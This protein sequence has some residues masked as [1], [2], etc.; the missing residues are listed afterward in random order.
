M[1]HV[2]IFIMLKGMGRLVALKVPERFM[3]ARHN[4]RIKRS[5]RCRPKI[6]NNTSIK[7]IASSEGKRDGNDPHN[8]LQDRNRKYNHSII[9]IDCHLHLEVP[10][11]IITLGNMPFLYYYFI[12]RQRFL[13]ICFVGRKKHC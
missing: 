4:T 3:N 13:F 12:H 8:K 5:T 6:K 10:R 11:K 9:C 1:S 7:A 2:D